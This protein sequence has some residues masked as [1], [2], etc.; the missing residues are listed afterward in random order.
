MKELDLLNRIKMDKNLACMVLTKDRHL[1]YQT[2]SAFANEN[3]G[4]IVLGVKKYKQGFQIKEIENPQV[5]KEEIFKNLNNDKEVSCNLL[6]KENIYEMKLLGK[7]II[8]IE[9]PRAKRHQ[10]PIYLKNNPYLHTYI[11]KDFRNQVCTRDEVNAMMRENYPYDYDQRILDYYDEKDIDLKALHDYMQQYK[12]RQEF[13]ICDEK[14]FLLNIGAYAIDKEHHKEGLTVA[15]AL[16]FGKTSVFNNVSHY[17]QLI[18]SHSHKRKRVENT[19]MEKNLYNYIRYINTHIM[20]D[21]PLFNEKQSFLQREYQL[22]IMNAIINALIHTDYLQGGTILIEKRDN[23]LRFT[24]PGEL[25]YSVK[26]C[27]NQHLS[28]PKNALLCQMF[29]YIDLAKGTGEGLSQIFSIQSKQVFQTIELKEDI[30]RR[31]VSL[32]LQLKNQFNDLERLHKI[33]KELTPSQKT[34]YSMILRYPRITISQMA[35]ILNLHYMTIK[36]VVISLY[37]KGLIVEDKDGY[38]VYESIFHNKT[39]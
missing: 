15:G 31:Q 25:V 19:K 39:L 38:L 37:R 9:V 5:I 14:D 21:C 16:M 34:I 24:N 17:T 23:Y 2:Y 20:Q 10:K 11:R 36:S 33:F 29:Y 8:I 12:I 26:E 1:L 7:T 3:G 28:I 32:Y 35:E 22:T 4:M 27:L 6:Q 18:V 13:S 30:N